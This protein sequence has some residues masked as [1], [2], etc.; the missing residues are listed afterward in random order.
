MLV[1]DDDCFVSSPFQFG[2]GVYFADC[3]SK[4]ANYCFPSPSKTTGLMLL[5]EVALGHPHELLSADY[6]VQ[7]LLKGKHSVKGL[8]KMAPDPSK[9]FTMSA[10][11]LLSPSFPSPS[12]FL[13]ACPSSDAL[14]FIK[15]SYP[16]DPDCVCACD[17]RSNGCT[18]PL[19]PIMDTG[20]ANPR[21]YT[22][23]Y[24][25][26]VVYDTA[27]IKMRYLVKLKFNFT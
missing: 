12:R 19:G 15:I 5:S 26:F 27:Q 13:S 17:V 11:L 2:K 18:V 24:N 21:G 4:S 1:S 23:N 16:V 20:V 7:N 25:E 10:F 9:A 3:S 6:N 8:G 22:L 14:H